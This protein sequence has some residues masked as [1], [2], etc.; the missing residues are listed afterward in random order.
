MITPEQHAKVKEIHVHG[1]GH[2]ATMILLCDN[3]G[4]TTSG[5]LDY[6]SWVDDHQEKEPDCKCF[7]C[8]K[9]ERR[10]HAGEGK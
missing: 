9:D 5:M 10:Y 4:C 8:W 6:F 1:C 2:P 3:P 7:Q